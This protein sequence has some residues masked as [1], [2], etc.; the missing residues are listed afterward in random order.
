MKSA[1]AI[2]KRFMIKGATVDGEYLNAARQAEKELSA[3]LA[4]VYTY[5]G[6]EYRTGDIV[7]I[8]GAY[9]EN[10]NGYFLVTCA[11]P[12]CLYLRKVGKRGSLLSAYSDGAKSQWPIMSWIKDNDRR[13]ESRLSNAE[14]ATLKHAPN[15]PKA[16]SIAYF[17]ALANN[18]A[19]ATEFR[20][21]GFFEDSLTDNLV[22]YAYYTEVV[23]RMTAVEAGNG[24]DVAAGNNPEPEVEYKP[25]CY[26]V[27]AIVAARVYF[28][29]APSAAFCMMVYLPRI[30]KPPLDSS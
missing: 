27:S 29:S 21:R 20:T 3:F 17:Q 23:A 25:D 15:V 13:V 22:M 8:T 26:L 11:F 14:C 6:T 16:D 12:D 18:E 19:Y 9:F 5:D 2:D 4:S 1:S 10:D 24:E 7:E 28:P 30:Y